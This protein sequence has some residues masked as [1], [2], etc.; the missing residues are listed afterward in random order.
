MIDD[1]RRLAITDAPLKEHPE[2]RERAPSPWSAV[3]S[4]VHQLVRIHPL[5]NPLREAARYEMDGP[6]TTMTHANAITARFWWL[7]AGEFQ[8]QG[9]AARPRW[10]EPGSGSEREHVER[11]ADY[12]AKK[13]LAAWE[14][15]GEL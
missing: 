2:K 4:G 12:L 8:F 6:T 11:V 7:G 14:N 3:A 10:W 5:L 15:R 9:A 13:L 1:A